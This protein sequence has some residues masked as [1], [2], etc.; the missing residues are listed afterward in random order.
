LLDL[1]TWE[2]QRVEI[3]FG[4]VR[5]PEP[6]LGQ[7][8]DLYDG[9]LAYTDDNL[10]RLLRALSEIGLEESTVVVVAGDHGL[11]F[12]HDFTLYDEVL[13]VPLVVR[14]PGRVAP[15]TTYKI[16]RLLA[17]RFGSGATILK[18]ARINKF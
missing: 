1:A 4:K 5:Y 8:R 13:R 7:V 11:Y 15:G 17:G 3:F 12:T 14:M 6:A 9:A 18:C 2:R 16:A 10:A